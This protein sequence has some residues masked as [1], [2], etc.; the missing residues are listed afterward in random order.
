MKILLEV[1]IDYVTLFQQGNETIE[2][3]KELLKEQRE[4]LGQKMENMKKP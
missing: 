2:A 4:Q 3:R 1:L